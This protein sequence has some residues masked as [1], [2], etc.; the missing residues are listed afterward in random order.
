MNVPGCGPAQRGPA[1]QDTGD[2]GP[3]IGNLR[4]DYVLPSRDLPVR[5]V[6]ITGAGSGV[7]RAF[8]MAAPRFDMPGHCR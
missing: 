6:V 5:A 7:G 8:S 1:A 4:L 3:R 2:F